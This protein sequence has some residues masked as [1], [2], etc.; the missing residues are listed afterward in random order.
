[1]RELNAISSGKPFY[2]IP[3]RAKTRLIDNA[4]K[5]IEIKWLYG[6]YC[7]N[8]V[9][10][11]IEVM[12]DVNMKPHQT[13]VIPCIAKGNPGPYVSWKKVGMDQPF[14]AGEHRVSYLGGNKNYGKIKILKFQQAWL[15]I[16]EQN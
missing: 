5:R 9:P 10:P 8:A 6:N 13:L 1:M 12:Q 7:L 4:N 14:R 16:R 15:Q 2:K 3:E 11:E